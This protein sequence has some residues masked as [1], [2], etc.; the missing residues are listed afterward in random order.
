MG[1]TLIIGRDEDICC[2][3]VHERLVGLGR[4]VIYLPE[5]RLFPG[6][7][8]VWQLNNGKSQGRFGFTTQDVQFS[9]IDG[10]LARFYGIA[11]Q[12]REAPLRWMNL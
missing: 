12:N 7:R 10:V 4:E 6:L 3:L 9:D 8:V 5:D 11:D 1:C 2:R